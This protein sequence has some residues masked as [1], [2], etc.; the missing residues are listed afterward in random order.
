MILLGTVLLAGALGLF[1]FYLIHFFINRPDRIRRQRLQAVIQ[2]GGALPEAETTTPRQV[3]FKKPGF[4]NKL[5][6][7]LEEVEVLKERQE[8]VK[9]FLRQA[10]VQLTPTELIYLVGL[11]FAAPLVFGVVIGRPGVGLLFGMFGGY[12]PFLYMRL[13]VRRRRKAF[14]NQLSDTLTI[15]S[16]SLKSGYSFL[17]AVQMIA[18]DMAAPIAEEFERML[19]EIRMG[20]PTEEALQSLNARVQ[21]QDFDLIVTAIIIQKQVGGNLAEI[22]DN[23]Q[24]TIRERVRIQGEIKAMTAQGRFSALIFMVLPLGLGAL[25]YTINPEYI[26]RLFHS[27]IGWGMLGVAL[28]GQIIGGLFINKIVKIEV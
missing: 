22:L 16:N 14:D 21:S 28:I 7:R 3:R 17:Q 20:I 9:E 15:M 19:R 4:V 23:I 10:G 24:D 8:G 27:P 1:Y 25:L 11:L 12:S 13:K 5:S 18:G 6:E 2:G 26:G